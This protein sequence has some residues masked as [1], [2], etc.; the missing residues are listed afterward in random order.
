MEKSTNILKL[1][2]SKPETVPEETNDEGEKHVAITTISCVDDDVGSSRQSA[3]HS[4][5]ALQ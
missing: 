5:D 2:H 1:N 3:G 4:L